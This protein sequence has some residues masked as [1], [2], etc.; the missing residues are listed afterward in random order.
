VKKTS[1]IKS[2]V[3]GCIRRDENAWS[4]FI[5]RFSRLVRWSAQDRLKDGVFYIAMKMLRILRN[6]SSHLYGRRIS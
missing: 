4:E 5:G 3:E 1:D 6:R 2:L